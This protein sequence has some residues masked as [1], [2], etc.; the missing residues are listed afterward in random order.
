MSSGDKR[1]SSKPMQRLV[2]FLFSDEEE[3][4]FQKDLLLSTTVQFIPW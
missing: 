3:I 2:L 4:S 1:A